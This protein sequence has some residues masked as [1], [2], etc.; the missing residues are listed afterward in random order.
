[1]RDVH[2]S[3]SFKESDENIDQPWRLKK[4][5]LKRKNS[6]AQRVRLFSSTFAHFEISF[7]NIDD[8]GIPERETPSFLRDGRYQIDFRRFLPESRSPLS[9]FFAREKRLEE[10]DR[11]VERR[12]NGG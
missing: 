1:M 4:E 5:P 2:R 12:K 11:H 6:S 9:T 8:E 10:K 7:S 3:L